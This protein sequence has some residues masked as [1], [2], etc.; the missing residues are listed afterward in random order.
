MKEQNYGTFLDA[1][2]EQERKEALKRQEERAR[3]D[4]NV[5]AFY[6][7]LVEVVERE[8]IKSQ[9]VLTCSVGKDSP[10]SSLRWAVTPTLTEELN[11][12]RFSIQ[13]KKTETDM[14]ATFTHT[15]TMPPSL[16]PKV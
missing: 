11:S 14:S 12:K 8:G 9:Y 13:T 1:W 10:G 4:A 16:M 3:E 7:H 2:R 15:I 6:A 5:R